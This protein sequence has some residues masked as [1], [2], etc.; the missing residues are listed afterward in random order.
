MN[1]GF[2]AGTDEIGDTD[3][4]VT[5]VFTEARLHLCE[6]IPFVTNAGGNGTDILS[7]RYNVEGL[8]GLELELILKGSCVDTSVFWEA[9]AGD[10]IW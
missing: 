10:F 2:G 8:A 5:T 3:G 4:A 7:Q 6:G 9:Y 1:D